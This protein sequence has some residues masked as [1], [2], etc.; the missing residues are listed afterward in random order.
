VT[1]I[2]PNRYQYLRHS[3]DSVDDDSVPVEATSLIVTKTLDYMYIEVAQRKHTREHTLN[4]LTLFG[5][6]NAK[7]TED[8]VTE[9][10]AMSTD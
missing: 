9:T 3:A 4:P 2:K 8:F 10:T 6:L 1:I 7:S 5:W